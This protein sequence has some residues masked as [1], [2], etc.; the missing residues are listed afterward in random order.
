[1]RLLG[2][3]TLIAKIAIIDDDDAVR[4]SMLALLES[5]GYEVSAYASA[6]EFLNRSQDGAD[7][8][9]VDH[10]MPGMTGLDLLEQLRAAGDRTPALMITAGVDQAMKP[11]AE[12]IG[13]PLMQKPVAEEQLV[14][15]IEEAR[16]RPRTDQGESGFSSK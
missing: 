1:L 5:Y 8:L 7:F 13:V 2:I 12:R 16:T 14:L 9:L 6:E 10:H 11:R 3:E 4:D 15:H